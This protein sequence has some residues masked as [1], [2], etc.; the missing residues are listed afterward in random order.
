MGLSLAI[1]GR[2][3]PDV[4]LTKTVMLGLV[5]SIHVLRR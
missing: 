2:L 1:S 3:K 4:K 5:P